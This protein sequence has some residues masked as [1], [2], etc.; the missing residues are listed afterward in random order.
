M[1]PLLMTCLA[2]GLA[3][4]DGGG[5]G[6]PDFPLRN[7]PPPSSGNQSPERPSETVP[8]LSSQAP[9]SNSQLPSTN[10]QSVGP[11][12]G[13]ALCAQAIAVLRAAGCELSN[14]AA[15]QCTTFTAATHPCRLQTEEW[16]SCV[17]KGTV[18]NADGE[19]DEEAPCASQFEVL[20]SCINGLT[21]ARTCNPA[22][23]CQNC[24]SACA[25]CQC[26]VELSPDTGL[27]CDA[28]CEYD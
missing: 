24:S 21:T 7:L 15:A 17:A 27:S 4:C 8:P 10:S 22:D 19:F 9:A 5:Q 18:C 16:L 25:Q 3:A 26:L 20:E 13:S 23:N 28:V 12:A 14:D 6:S 2:F 11:G 1:K